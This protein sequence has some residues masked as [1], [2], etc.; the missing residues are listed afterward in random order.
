VSSPIYSRRKVDRSINEILL[1]HRDAPRKDPAEAAQSFIYVL[2]RRLLRQE[3]RPDRVEQVISDFE[4]A[5]RALTDA[6]MSGATVEEQAEILQAYWKR[7]ELPDPDHRKRRDT[8]GPTD[9]RLRKEH[10]TLRLQLTPIL[11][12]RKKKD[13]KAIVKELRKLAPKATKKARE[14][15]AES[16][17]AAAA[18]ILL[19]SRHH[20]G[21][22]TIRNRISKA[23]K[24]T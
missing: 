10:E 9:A 22:N 2:T 4:E 20:L 7:F 6:A 12:G 1:E 21:P 24:Q 23:K 16:A 15:A 17:P 3:A 5:A 18:Y 13:R 19:G 14:D 11:R 8:R